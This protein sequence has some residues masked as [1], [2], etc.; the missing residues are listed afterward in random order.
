MDKKFFPLLTQK[1][2][3]YISGEFDLNQS[4]QSFVY[5]NP[6]FNGTKTSISMYLEAFKNL[7]TGKTYKRNINTSL[8]IFYLEHIKL[9]YPDSVFR[10]SLLSTRGHLDYRFQSSGQRLLVLENYLSINSFQSYA[11]TD[12]TPVSKDKIIREKPQSASVKSISII[13]TSYN[14]IVV[15]VF[16]T[17]SLFNFFNVFRSD[18]QSVVNGT[19]F[20]LAALIS[21]LKSLKFFK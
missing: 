10:I 8:H 17:L 21:I 14:L 15:V 3:K 16:F 4:I 7:I 13:D 2:E 19:L 6:N 20:L 9:N 12:D 1:A 18:I 5:E 11:K